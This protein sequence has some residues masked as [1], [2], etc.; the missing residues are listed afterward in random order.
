M[1]G[2]DGGVMRG[3]GRSSSV[4]TDHASHTTTAAA[5][6]RDMLVTSAGRLRVMMGLVVAETRLGTVAR[7]TATA[8]MA[9]VK[10]GCT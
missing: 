10:D 7:T 5:A 3:N 1:G 4:G 6:M 9:V 2:G 8:A